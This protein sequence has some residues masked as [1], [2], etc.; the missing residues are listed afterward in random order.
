MEYKIELKNVSKKF[1]PFYALN[2]ISMHV[3]KGKIYG[4]I[5]NNGAGKSTIMKILNG[6]YYCN[7]GEISISQKTTQKELEKER[8]KFGS[9]IDSPNIIENMTAIQ[10]L[11][12]MKRL[13][14]LDKSV[15]TME[16]LKYINLENTGRK[17][18]KQFSTGM[19]GRLAL[20]MA[21]MGRPEVLLLDEP[22]NG[23]DPSGI[24]KIRNMI[25]DINLNYNTTIIVSSHILNELSLIAD[26][27]GFIHEGKMIEEISKENLSK[28][29][30][31]YYLIS[32]DDISLATVVIENLGIKDYKV[33]ADKKLIVYDTSIEPKKIIKALN[34]E[35]IGIINFNQEKILLEDYFIKLIEEVR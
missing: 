19:K 15:N 24:I 31:S 33:S 2:D 29:C 26:N 4:L 35:D 1:G 30:N 12:Y 22:T 21:I 14:G 13:R 7:S 3:P 8:E 20:A 18:A 10:N 16:L 5:G 6:D 28:K 32:V 25:R 34:N 23:I 17:R 9:L 11:E 27:Y